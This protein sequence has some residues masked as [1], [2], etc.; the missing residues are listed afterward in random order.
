[1][2]KRLRG[3]AVSAEESSAEVTREQTA[4]DRVNGREGVRASVF[5]L[6]FAAASV[7]D[8]VR[9]RQGR[10]LRRASA[11]AATVHFGEW[12]RAATTVRGCAEAATRHGCDRQ[13]PKQ[14]PG[15][16]AIDKRRSSD[17]A[18]VRSTS[19]EA[20]TRPGCGR[21]APK[22]R[23]GMGAVDVSRT[24]VVGHRRGRRRGGG[25]SER[26]LA[27]GRAPAGNWLPNIGDLSGSH[28]TGRDSGLT[29]PRMDCRPRNRTRVGWSALPRGSLNGG[30]VCAPL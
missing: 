26:A 23:P 5:P 2:T 6:A 30:R 22:Q 13:A 4:T 19:A 25:F 9:D 17:Q 24:V 14:R 21:Q 18:W 1:M 28:G 7:L 11:K 16:G 8:L 27:T 12:T 15:M 20:A 10:R 29:K 3:R